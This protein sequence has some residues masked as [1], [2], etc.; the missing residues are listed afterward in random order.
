MYNRPFGRTVADGTHSNNWSNSL[1]WG[2]T[3]SLTDNSK[4]NSYL[5]ESL[6]QF[7]TRNYIWTRI[8]N[9]GRSN[10]LL[11]QPGSALPPNFTESPIGHVAAYTI[12]YDRDFHIASHLLAAPGAQFTTYTTPN[13]LIST[14]GAHPYG[15]VAFL[16]LRISR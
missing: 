7:H 5:L 15:A 4:E 14:Y 2:R 8:E 9:A 10:E 16:R 1:V 6:L 12:G 11:L 13:S 3:K